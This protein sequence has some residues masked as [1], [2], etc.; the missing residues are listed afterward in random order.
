MLIFKFGGRLQHNTLISKLLTEY[1]CMHIN[2]VY[3]ASF[4]GG[5]FIGFIVVVSV[6]SIV[7]CTGFSGN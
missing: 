2:I 6:G 5:K 1:L 7:C 3:A 4:I